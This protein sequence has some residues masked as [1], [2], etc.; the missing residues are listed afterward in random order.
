MSKKNEEL[1][2]TL[3][4]LTKSLN[5]TDYYLKLANVVQNE[6]SLNLKLLRITQ[7]ETSLSNLRKNNRTALALGLSTFSAITVGV[8][9][10]SAAGALSI[11]LFLPIFVGLTAATIF[12]CGFLTP[13]LLKQYEIQQS[14]NREKQENGLQTLNEI[15]SDS[16]IKKE[17]EGIKKD[18]DNDI[19]SYITHLQGRKQTLEQEISSVRTKIQ[20]C[21]NPASP[22]V[23]SNSFFT[24]KKQA[25]TPTTAPTPPQHSSGSGQ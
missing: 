24:S 22:T 23:T 6:T 9:A 11:T 16:D 5:D 14:L 18:A 25:T 10:L 1:R 7:I 4:G 13:K 3:E 15:N 8:I 20:P 17:F 12:I 21:Q 2:M 19:N